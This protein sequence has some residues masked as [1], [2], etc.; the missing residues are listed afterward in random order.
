[1][2]YLKGAT[3]IQKIIIILF[4]LTIALS[5]ISLVGMII[6]KPDRVYTYCERPGLSSMKPVVLNLAN[7]SS[8]NNGLTLVQNCTT[9]VNPPM[10]TGLA[11]LINLSTT[12]AGF[13]LAG[14]IIAYITRNKEEP[15]EK[16]EQ[17]PQQ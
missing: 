3:S 16:E 4:I 12:C 8:E 10:S 13:F 9:T 11:L 7:I 2:P 5:C 17:T 14:A 6:E 1:M 15:D